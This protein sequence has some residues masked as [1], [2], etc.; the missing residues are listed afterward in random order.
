MSRRRRRSLCGVAAEPWAP[1][2]AWC[3]SCRWTLHHFLGRPNGHSTNL[4]PLWRRKWIGRGEMETAAVRWKKSIRILFWR[5]A[6]LGKLTRVGKPESPPSPSILP[7]SPAP[8][9]RH[10]EREKRARKNAARH[11]W[12]GI[13]SRSWTKQ[14]WLGGKSFSPSSAT[15]LRVAFTARGCAQAARKGKR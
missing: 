9:A 12:V 13:L 8:L 15:N 4:R 1:R 7:S 10:K 3:W 14:L 6:L 2:S 5:Q 11:S